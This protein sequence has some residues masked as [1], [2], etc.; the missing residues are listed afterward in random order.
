MT[1]PGCR[2]WTTWWHCS[3]TGRLQFP[4][5]RVVQPRALV[6]RQDAAPQSEQVPG[7]LGQLT[8]PPGTTGRRE[9]RR[10]GRGA[11][12]ARWAVHRSL[13]AQRVPHPAGA[14]QETA[15]LRDRQPGVEEVI[16][17]SVLAAREPLTGPRDVDLKTVV[18]LGAMHQPGPAVRQREQ[19]QRVPVRLGMV[20]AAVQFP[21]ELAARLQQCLGSRARNQ[22]HDI[23]SRSHDRGIE[24]AAVPAVPAHR[25]RPAQP[26]PP[27]AGRDIHQ[28]LV[29]P[30]QGP[31]PRCSQLQ[32]RSLPHSRS[33]PQP[34]TPSGPRSQPARRRRQAPPRPA[35]WCCR[36]VPKWRASADHLTPLW[37]LDRGNGVLTSI[38]SVKDQALLAGVTVIRT[39]LAVTL[40][41]S[42][43]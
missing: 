23:R 17:I 27:P 13:P 41:F 11:V 31:R 29:M 25:L 32:P 43:R 14:E 19:R 39:Y 42:R 37:V 20:V 33:L 16:R 35:R 26:V 15:V 34:R 22:R 36:P 18:L 30:D 28:P 21:D 6:Q 7:G 9:R 10:P 24:T 4:G 1:A 2:S 12:A 5:H 8:D 3:W 38:W 40:I